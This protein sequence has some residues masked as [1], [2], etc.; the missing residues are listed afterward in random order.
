MNGLTQTTCLMAPVAFMGQHK[1][2]GGEL[3]CNNMAGDGAKTP[4]SRRFNL[5]ASLLPWSFHQRLTT[6]PPASV[7]HVWYPDHGRFA[8]APSR[9]STLATSAI[10]RFGPVDNTIFSS[11]TSASQDTLGCPIPVVDSLR[12]SSKELRLWSSP[13]SSAIARLS[14][15]DTTCAGKLAMRATCIPKLRSHEPVSTC[16]AVLTVVIQINV[17]LI[18]YQL[19]LKTLVFDVVGAR[20]A[21]VT[22]I[23][24]IH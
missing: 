1:E 21:F 24:I 3:H 9:C 16:G 6:P 11:L 14:A 13:L 8:P 10:F 12:L 2:Y 22:L 4:I 7:P 18:W 15:S 20:A 5:H 23:R 17:L 19:T